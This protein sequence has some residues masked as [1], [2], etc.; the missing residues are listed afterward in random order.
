MA[1]K[2]NPKR[3][4]VDLFAGCGGLSLGLEQAG[5]T[6]V[7][8]NEINP[9]AMATY[10]K[11]RTRKF[12]YLGDEGRHIDD[13][14][15]LFSD[16][17]RRLRELEELLRAEYEID[18]DSNP[19]DLIV[20]GPPCQGFSGIGHRRSYDI[21]REHVPANH[22]YMDMVK[23]IRRL[24]PKLFLF[25][26]VR[27]LLTARWGPSGE[28]RGVWK[29]VYGAF[30]S[31]PGYDIAYDVLRA[32]DYGV[33]Q[34]RPRVLLVGVRRDM[35]IRLNCRSA[36]AL[37]A[38]LLPPPSRRAAPHLIELLD[39][40]VPDSYRPGQEIT[41]YPVTKKLT[42]LQIRLRGK[43]ARKQ[44]TDHV[45]SRHS[46]RVLEK[47]Q[48]MLDHKGKIAERHRTK[49][50]AQRLLEPR[51]D[52][53]KGPTITACSLPD[54]YVHYSQPRALTVREWAR[55]QL[56]PDRYVFEG[57]RTTGGLRRAG[58]PL[59]GIVDRE[60]PKYTQIGN[61]VPVELARRI[62]VH[63]KALLRKSQK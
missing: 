51:W 30:Q 20:G 33:P 5:W 23:V 49:K 14:R 29:S 35:K 38:G 52:P 41:E 46:P 55:L 36:R 9:D 27:G 50:F 31:L 1:K 48:F 21:D 37:E 57:K 32:K 3:Y 6:P 60:L 18:K 25:E 17:A 28:P 7:F 26:N 10:L 61:A 13:I 43:R 59:A 54:D 12:R 16:K 58:N 47:F 62:G 19:L 8:V 15:K 44:L 39:D 22:L 24:R 2:A 56:F 63:F 4:F 11:N 42:A 40:L 53:K 45:I 34:N